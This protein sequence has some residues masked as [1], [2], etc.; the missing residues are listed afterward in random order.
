VSGILPQP[1]GKLL[2][3]RVVRLV[4]VKSRS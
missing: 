3:L 1:I 2:H 4:T